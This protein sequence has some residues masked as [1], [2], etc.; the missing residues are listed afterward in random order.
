VPIGLT[1][2]AQ[3]LNLPDLA[4]QELGHAIRNIAAARRVAP[5][6]PNIATDFTIRLPTGGTATILV[7]LFLHDIWVK[8]GWY[9]AGDIVIALPDELG[10]PIPIPC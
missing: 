3:R 10:P 5:A 6:V 8:G 2:E 1:K 4:V 9:R 7:V